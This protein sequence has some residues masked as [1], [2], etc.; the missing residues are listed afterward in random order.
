MSSK[1]TLIFGRHPVVEAITAGESLERIMLQQG[2]RG[3]FEK[4]IRQLSKKHHIPL[5]IVPKERLNKFTRSNHQGIVGLLANIRY[6]KVEDVLP[7]IYEKGE[8][9]LLAILDGV[10]DVRNF[11][12]I[13]RSALCC[14]VHTIIIPTKG[15]AQINSEAI[16]TS[17]GA[18][19]QIPVCREL[20][21]IKTIEQL[22]LSGIQV[23]A[24]DL[25]AN[26]YIQTVDL[27]LPTAV[28]L[29]SEGEGVSQSVL[30]Q[31]NQRFIIPQKELT[32]S[33]NVAVASGIIF[34]EAMRQRL[35]GMA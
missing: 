29:G 6:Y 31:V 34:Y 32:D 15:V 1:K 16:K 13:A 12:A 25:Q 7:M 26:A 5:Q 10:T 28:V 20:S 23:L 2:T 24:S 8:T 22:Q 3:D 21:L 27:S 19:H 18:L 9:P 33:F 11:G 17:A 14:G 35:S 4:T 30:K